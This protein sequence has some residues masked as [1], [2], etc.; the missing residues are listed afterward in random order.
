MI[1]TLSADII[2]QFAGVDARDRL[3]GLE[4]FAEIDSTNSYLMQ[5]GSPAPR[6]LS[7][8]VTANQTAGRGRHGKIWQS[9]PGSGVC[10][11]IAYT[12]AS[13]PGNLPALT[14]AL[15]LGALDALHELGAK[16]IE[17]KWPNDLV[18]LDGK[19]GGIL[20]E[21]KPPSASSVTVVA[22]V[23]VNVD[24]RSPLDLSTEGDWAQQV[25]DLARL[26]AQTPAHDNVAGVLVKTL[27]ASLTEYEKAG[28][29]PLAARWSD[30]DWL[31][32]RKVDLDTACGQVSGIAAGIAED[33]ALL[34][35]TGTAGLQ[36]VISGSILS[37][38]GRGT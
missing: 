35:D 7:V 8:A 37:A 38:G 24:V 10:L 12:F 33:G 17:L 25:T 18:A 20:T 28:F 32:G 27:L 6:Q 15:G 16:G 19:L 1:P 36:R 3:A 13:K 22:G 5:A 9:P 14:L 4:V 11:S 34:I 30:Y 21:V 26:C 2:R 23:G 29:M 31:R